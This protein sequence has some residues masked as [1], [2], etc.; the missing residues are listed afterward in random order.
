[1]K[2]LLLVW[3]VVTGVLLLASCTDTRAPLTEVEQAEKYNMTQKEFQET[4]EAAARM[5][6]TIED[7]MKMTDT[8]GWTNHDMMDMS[9][10]SSMIEDYS[11]I[12]HT[13]DDGTMMTYEVMHMETMHNGENIEIHGSDKHGD[14]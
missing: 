1:M 13:M 6:M 14:H 11:E 12:M 10:D 9:D 2:K 8:S 3:M 5:N 7:H 4:K